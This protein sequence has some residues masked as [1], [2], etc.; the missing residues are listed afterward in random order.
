MNNGFAAIVQS[1]GKN[2]VDCRAKDKT[3]Q[4]NGQLHDIGD[5]G[6]F[7]AQQRSFNM[8]CLISILQTDEV[9]AGRQRI[10]IFRCSVPVNLID[11]RFFKI[12]FEHETAVQRKYSQET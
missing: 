2:I 8:F 11:A 1:V 12:P 10:A 7:L 6:R 5:S 4:T 3:E 9:H